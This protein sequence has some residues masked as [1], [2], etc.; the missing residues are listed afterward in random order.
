MSVFHPDPAGSDPRARAREARRS[1]LL[2]VAEEV[3]AE[4]GFARAKVAEIAARAG[5]SAGS[6]YNNF[7]S[8]ED[9]FRE[10]IAWR[11]AQTL[12]LFTRALEHDG[13][14]VL[15]TVDRFLDTVF[16]FWVGHRAFFRIFQDVTSGFD[17]NLGRLGDQAA[18][19]V[20]IELEDRLE[21]LLR[22][23]IEGGELAGG[24]PAL[25]VCLLTGT[26]NRWI[27]R[28]L[29][30]DAEAEDLLATLPDVKDAIHRALGAP[31]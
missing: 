14:P 8:K 7:D 11:G 6:L 13:G 24:H 2:E 25:L 22:E 27:A 31:S 1:A 9:L 4:H 10:L 16:E 20:R 23:G 5:Y 18:T 30:D 15:A 3:F 26:V 17:W 12:A 19:T 28:W 21:A 29:R